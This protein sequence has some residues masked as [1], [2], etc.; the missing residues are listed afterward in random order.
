MRTLYEK[1]THYVKNL[2]DTPL[3]KVLGAETAILSKTLDEMRTAMFV[4]VILTII[5]FCSGFIASY[6]VNKI[7]SWELRQS[8]IKLL[9][10]LLLIFLGSFVNVACGIPWIESA[11]LGLI[12]TTELISILENIELISPNILPRKIL[13]RFGITLSRKK[14]KRAW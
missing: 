11:F 2:I 9:V 14:K 13:N 12:V 8:M 10:Y 1:T 4:V 7:S 5:D 6:K 3:I